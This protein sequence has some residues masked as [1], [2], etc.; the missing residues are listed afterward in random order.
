MPGRVFFFEDP[1]FKFSQGKFLEVKISYLNFFEFTTVM[2]RKP[3]VF[4]F[5]PSLR[6]LSC[7][8]FWRSESRILNFFELTIVI[9]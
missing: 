7:I 9:S 2:S 5:I 6:G 8:I 1:G 3:M 4:I